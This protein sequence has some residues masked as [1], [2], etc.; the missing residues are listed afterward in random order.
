MPRFLLYA[1]ASELGALA[2]LAAALTEAG[3]DAECVTA[4][5]PRPVELDPLRYADAFAEA[6]ADAF[7][8]EVRRARPDAIVLDARDAFVLVAGPPLGHPV[9]VRLGAGGAPIAGVPIAGVH[10]LAVSPAPAITALERWI[11]ACVP[12]LAA[13]RAA[14][15]RPASRL[16]FSPGARG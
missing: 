12:E 8:R 2:P 3:H 9:T 6:A 11:A 1:V 13:W 10:E 15:D 16:V 14:L 7:A 5:R 4:A